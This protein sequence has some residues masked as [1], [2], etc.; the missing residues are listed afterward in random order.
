MP[1]YTSYGEWIAE[2]D[3]VF[4]HARL[5][6][7]YNGSAHGTVNRMRRDITRTLDV[8]RDGWRQVVFGPAEVFGRPDQVASYVRSLLDERDPGWRARR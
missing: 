1:I 3:L 5:T 6:L 4:E 8:E 2:P 7:E